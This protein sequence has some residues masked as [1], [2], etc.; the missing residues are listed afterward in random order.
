MPLTELRIAAARAPLR[1]VIR[2]PISRGWPCHLPDVTASSATLALRS[3]A[4]PGPL[5]AFADGG[6]RRYMSS[7]EDGGRHSTSHE[8]TEGLVAPSPATAGQ[9]LVTGTATRTVTAA[10][11]NTATEDLSSGKPPAASAAETGAAAAAA[12]LVA[13][14]TTATAA[15]AEAAADVAEEAT[16]A[17]GNFEALQAALALPPD[18]PP[19]ADP[20]TAEHHAW[21]ST[22][23]LLERFE[24]RQQYEAKLE[25]AKAKLEAVKARQRGALVALIR[26]AV[27]A[28]DRIDQLPPDTSV[29]VGEFSAAQ[30]ESVRRPLPALRTVPSINTYLAPGAKFLLACERVTVATNATN[31]SAIATRPSILET[32][33]VEFVMRHDRVVKVRETLISLGLANKTVSELS[34]TVP[35]D[36]ADITRYW[37]TRFRTRR[38][39]MATRMNGWKAQ[40]RKL[41]RPEKRCVAS[42]AS[43]SAC[44]RRTSG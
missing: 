25:A 6:Q 17:Q 36:W 20:L 9:H 8:V 23:S 40:R 34:S 44:A 3:A 27:D 38:R 11:A 33:V 2:C 15:A 7:M 37:R 35:D 21:V 39:R 12:S 19:P 31:A 10:A 30:S 26:D 32:G 4:G 28:K 24:K 1:S 43:S 5:A 41:P 22:M 14:M 42:P 18:A 29:W 16:R 13:T